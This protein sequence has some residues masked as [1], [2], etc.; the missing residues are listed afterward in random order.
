M[1]ALGLLMGQVWTAPIATATQ[2]PQATFTRTNQATIVDVWAK[3]QK[4]D[5]QLFVTGTNF[6]GVKMTP[7]KIGGGAATGNYQAHMVLSGNAV[8]PDFIHV[9]NSSSVPVVS[10]AAA[11]SDIVNISK[12]EYN[13]LDGSLCVVASSSD[14]LPITLTVDASPATYSLIAGNQDAKCQAPGPHDQSISAAFPSNNRSP[15][16][17]RVISGLKGASEKLVTVLGNTPDNTVKLVANPD[18]FTNIPSSGAPLD[19]GL[20]DGAGGTGFRAGEIVIVDQPNIPTV[21]A[22]GQP[23]T[24]IVGKVTGSL[25]G[26]TVTFTGNPGAAGKATFSYFIKDSTT[27][28][29]NVSN[30]VNASIDIAFV[31]TPPTGSPDNFAVLKNTAGFTANVL[32]NDIAAVGTTLKNDSVQIATQGTKGV[33]TV[34]TTNGTV[35]YTPTVGAAIG[36]DAFFY[37]VA[38]TAGT[39]STPIRV[40]VVVENAAENFAVSRVRMTKQNTGLKWDIRFTTLWFG[41]PLTPTG[42]CYLTKVGSTTYPISEAQRIGSALVDATGAVQLQTASTVP[43][44]QTFTISCNTSNSTGSIL[45]SGTAP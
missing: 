14:D 26:G 1:T 39:R 33:A 13:P 44:R 40:D 21:N 30:L 41:A 28:V 16:K 42:T 12:A 20:N 35:T 5:D 3:A 6:P 32:I 36:A 2:V 31:A 38:N 15:D 9:V 18:A 10:V 25:T 7:V 45:F 4:P 23:T 24:Q 17:V 19:V 8:L 22:N 11:L 27:P 37:T 43:S 34:N 29:A